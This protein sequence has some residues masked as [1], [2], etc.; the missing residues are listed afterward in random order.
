MFS[1]KIHLMTLL[2]LALN[3]ELKPVR[4]SK[5]YSQISITVEPVKNFLIMPAK[6]L[7]IAK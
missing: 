6:T 1:K 2:I 3:I 4:Q 5:I 7:M